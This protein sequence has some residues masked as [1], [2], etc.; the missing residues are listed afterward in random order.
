MD[1]EI[2]AASYAEI[3]EVLKTERRLGPVARND[4][5]VFLALHQE[6]LTG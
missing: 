3:P 1:G 4:G 5:R 2:E 6:H